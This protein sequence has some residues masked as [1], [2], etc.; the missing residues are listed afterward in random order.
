MSNYMKHRWSVGHNLLSGITL[1]AW[2]HLLRENQYNVDGAYAHRAAF[3]TTLAIGNSFWAGIEDARFGERIRNARLDAA[4]LFVLGHWRSGTTHLH[5]LIAQDEANF[6]FPNTYQVVNPSTFLCTEQMNSRLFA[7][8]LPATRP[9]DNMA[10]TFQSPQEDELALC[11]LSMK[12]PYLGV[13]FPRR[14]DHYLQYLSFRKSRPD[15]LATWKRAADFFF[16]KVSLNAKGRALVIKSPSHTARV[17]HLLD[18]YPNARFVHIHRDPY[19]VFQSSQHY[20]DTAGWYIYL[21]KPSLDTLDEQ[22]LSRHDVLFD[23]YFEDRQLIPKNQFFEMSFTDLET[24]PIQ[25]IQAMYGHFQITGFEAFLPRLQAYVRSLASYKKNEFVTLSPEK[26]HIVAQ[27][28]RR[29]F[30][31]WQYPT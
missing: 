10:M 9:M 19:T 5:N 23:A 25:Q 22:I 4:P 6:L 17:R 16:R 11:L 21:Q 2:L 30:D 29:C 24:N 15:E 8:L 14:N 12:S 27:R 26:R 28:W 3:L 31:E 20:F 18:L 7:G 13:S 1:P